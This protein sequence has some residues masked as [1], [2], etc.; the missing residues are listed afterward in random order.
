[1]TIHEFYCNLKASFPDMSLPL[2]TLSY[3]INIL[4]NEKNSSIY[5]V[6]RTPIPKWKGKY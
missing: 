6:T 3:A 5:I 4:K 2:F 1:M